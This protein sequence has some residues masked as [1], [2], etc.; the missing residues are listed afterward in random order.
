MQ[1]ASA[2]QAVAPVWKQAVKSISKG[3]SDWMAGML[4]SIL[5][6][7]IAF[8]PLLTLLFCKAGDP[9]RLA[10]WLTPILYIL[11]VLPLRYSMAEAALQAYQGGTFCTT[12]LVS[13]KRYGRKLSALISQGIRLLPWALPLSAA[14]G[15]GAYLYLGG[16]DSLTLM[17]MLQSLGKSLGG[18]SGFMEGVY[19]VAAGY[20]LLFLILLFGMMRNGMFRFV[21]AEMSGANQPA[22]QEM[23]RRLRGNRIRQF[24]IG[25]IQVVLLIPFTAVEGYLCYTGL[26][27]G[28]TPLLAVG[29]VIAAVV[30]YLPLLP[31]RKILPA[32]YIKAAGIQPAAHKA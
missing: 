30:L 8:S 12:A 23:L 29:M 4:V 7:L 22:R 24:A 27:T 32:M 31:I 16:V 17:R 5:V 18:E 26:R 15:Y 2:K 9:L 21:W 1:N 11:F 14:V 19:L 10:V 28:F 13:L 25:L 20:S 3:F 6:R